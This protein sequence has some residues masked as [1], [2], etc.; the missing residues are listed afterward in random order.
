MFEFAQFAGLWKGMLGIADTLLNLFNYTH[1]KKYL[2]KAKELIINSEILSHDNEKLQ[3]E[4]LYV[5]SKYKS[6]KGN[7]I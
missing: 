6:L 5:L 4:V 7:L 3:T 2:E 1:D